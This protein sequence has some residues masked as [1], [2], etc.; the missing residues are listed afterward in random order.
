MWHF[1]F[2]SAGVK[3]WESQT[4]ERKAA[5]YRDTPVII[6]R[7][8]KETALKYE[9]QNPHSQDCI[10][11]HCPA[12]YNS[13]GS[14][15][16]W[17]VTV[18]S[19]VWPRSLLLCPFHKKL[20]I[21]WKKSFGFCQADYLQFI[22]TMNCYTYRQLTCENLQVSELSFF[23]KSTKKKSLVIRACDFP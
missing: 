14:L 7:S 13:F 19:I 18:L 9:P 1:T 20:R 10:L 3:I 6:K 11:T 16:F 8:L 17:L 4:T 12:S 23:R 2:T 22:W 5:F 15:W 21:C